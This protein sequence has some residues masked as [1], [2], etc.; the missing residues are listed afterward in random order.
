MACLHDVSTEPL[1]H[2]EIVRMR[3]R[4]DIPL[5]VLGGIT[6][7]NLPQL[8]AMGLRRVAVCRGICRA[9]NISRRARFMKEL[10]LD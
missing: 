7:E 8:V 6:P 9:D 3:R 5:F 4:L 1:R 2:S 10:L